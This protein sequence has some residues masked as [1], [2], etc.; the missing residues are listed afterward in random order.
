VIE[1]RLLGRTGLAVS[2]IGFGTVSLGVDY[3][4]A[5]PGEFGRPPDEES[6]ALLRRA[7]ALGVALYDTAPAY[8]QSERILGTALGADAA[9]VF[10]TKVTVPREQD[11]RASIDTSLDRSCAALGRESL[12]V[13]QIHNATVESLR[14]GALLD[15]LEEARARG[16]LRFIGASVY[17]EDE[18]LAAIECGRVDVLQVAYNLLDQR[19]AQ[20]VFPAARRANVGVLVRSAFLKGALT[21]KAAHLPAALAELRRAADR[22]RATLG[23]GWS[24]LPEMALRFCLSAP[25]VSTALFGARTSEELEM[26][27]AAAE[28]GP[29]PASL[30]EQLAAVAL[31]DDNL[32]NPAKWPPV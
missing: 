11:L 2:S 3:G 24:R 5:A 22:A 23:V 28:A 30:L 13:V 26:A 29:L 4:I 15:T 14:G 20:R 32:L 27:V 17:T 9:C 6:V 18:A 8:G 25:A 7:A 31:S 1:R 12:D 10:A 19:M 16:K 21:D